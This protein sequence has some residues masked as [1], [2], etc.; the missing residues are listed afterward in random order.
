MRK[1]IL[2]AGMAGIGFLV[3]RARRPSDPVELT[4][5]DMKN[6]QRPIERIE[7]AVDVPGGVRP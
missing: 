5:S 3:T 7:E 2:L 1:L 4:R 6:P